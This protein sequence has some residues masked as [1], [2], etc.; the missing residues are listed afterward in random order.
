VSKGDRLSCSF[1][2]TP[3]TRTKISKVGNRWI[4]WVKRTSQERTKVITIKKKIKITENIKKGCSKKRKEKKRKKKDKEKEKEK[5]KEKKGKV[6]VWTISLPCVCVAIIQLQQ[7]KIVRKVHLLF[8]GEPWSSMFEYWRKNKNKKQKT[9]NKKQKTKKKKKF[10]PPHHPTRSRL[11]HTLQSKELIE[12]CKGKNTLE[13][14]YFE[15]RGNEGLDLRFQ[16]RS[17]RCWS[18]SYNPGSIKN[19]SL[20]MNVK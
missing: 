17:N 4:V 8:G 18:C 12:S 5:E 7:K 13:Y 3:V 19:S 11:H 6:P 10:R 16:A 2:A 20:T 15:E 14:H 1:D 9:K